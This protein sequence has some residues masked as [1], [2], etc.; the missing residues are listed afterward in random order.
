MENHMSNIGYSRYDEPLDAAHDCYIHEDDV[1][2]MKH[3]MKTILD[4]VYG[5]RDIEDLEYE[6]ENLAAHFDLKLPPKAFRITRI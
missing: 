6:L 4:I 1:V 3:K 2:E 5:E